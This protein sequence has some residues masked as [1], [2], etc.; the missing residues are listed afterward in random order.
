MEF[1]SR[2]EWGAA[3]ARSI[4]R[5]RPERVT[6]FFLH[7]TTGGQ[8]H[9]RAAW[10]R[11]IQRFHQET[12][13][14]SDVAYSWLVDADGTIYEGR[15]WT[16]VGAH[17]RGHN[18]TGVAVAY[19]GDG[20]QSVPPAAL[21][22]IVKVAEEADRVFGRSLE[23]LPHKAVGNTTCP[24]E[25]LAAWLAAGMPIDRP[26]PAAPVPDLRAGWRRHLLRLRR[27]R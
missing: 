26:R 14:W 3:P 23:R 13:G 6:H 27:R 25:V 15:G 19:L 16:R 17:T 7:H 5:L 21:R 2:Q 22:A 20:R 11:G 12:R 8:Q 9:D 1:V 10:L 24:G 18:S 4:T